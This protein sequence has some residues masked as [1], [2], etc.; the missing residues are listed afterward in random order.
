MKNTRFFDFSDENL[1]SL[2][3]Q[4]SVNHSRSLFPAR[5]Y[6]KTYNLRPKTKLGIYNFRYYQSTHVKMKNITVNI[7]IEIV[8]KLLKIILKNI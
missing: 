7:T 5:L 2:V 3:I 6:G 1:F 8:S 4:I